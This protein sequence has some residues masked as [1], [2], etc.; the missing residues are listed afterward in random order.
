MAKRLNDTQLTVLSNAAARDNH[1]ILPLPIALKAPPTAVRKT[2]KSLLVDGFIEEIGATHDDEVWEQS[3]ERGRTTLVVTAVGL[4][5][6]GITDEPA[7]PTPAKARIKPSKRRTRSRSAGK[8]MK[9]A[10]KVSRARR[11]DD[12]G[13]KESKQATVIALLRR[14]Q[15]ASIE[16]MMAATGWQAHSVRGFMSGAL[17]KRLG[18]E[19]VSAKDKKTGERRYHV[20]AI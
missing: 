7:D 8:P 16:E 6:I 17:K 20:T 10:K 9:V 12:G 4:A 14:G 1:R 3:D 19:V 5:A 2:L 18:F 15:G 11:A 13:E